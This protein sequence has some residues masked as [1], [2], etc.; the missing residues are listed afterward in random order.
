[1]PPLRIL[2]QRAALRFGLALPTAAQRALFGAP[3]VNDLG[4]AL[5]PR[6]HALLRMQGTLGHTLTDETPA[7]ARQNLRDGIDIVAPRAPAVA[8]CHDLTLAGRP[9]RH[10]DP[11]APDAPLLLWMH[12]G[13]WA[14]GDLDSHD[15]F[16]RRLCAEGGLRVVAL[17]YRRSPE[18]PFPA[19]L[20]DTVA[21]WAEL[22]AWAAARGARP[23]RWLAGGDS[24][25]GNLAAA[26]CVRQHAAAAPLPDGLLLVYPGLDFRRDTA[27]HARFASGY[28]LEASGI[29][30]YERWYAIPSK[31]D[32]L[33]SPG[34]ADA[35]FPPAIVVTA[36]FDPLRD[37]GR[38]F[39]ARVPGSTHLDAAEQVHG[40]VHFD[41]LSPTADARVSEIMAAAREAW[42]SRP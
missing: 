40:F 34:L 30:R 37:E 39:A 23:T 3:P 7:R 9:A 11:G 26:L 13:G 21:A 27:S 5:D 33:A 17:D 32:P 6:V 20:D 25:G 18:H 2:A 15:G 10:Y 12:G 1:M 28:L 4:V 29:D 14:A 36:G 42:G 16:C 41:T 31:T 24:A 22:A 8:G 19:A 38:A 35:P